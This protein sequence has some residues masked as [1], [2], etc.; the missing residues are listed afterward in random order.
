MTDKFGIEKV[1]QMKVDEDSINEVPDIEDL[2]AIIRKFKKK[3]LEL[4]KIKTFI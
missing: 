4:K 1:R 2:I 3:F